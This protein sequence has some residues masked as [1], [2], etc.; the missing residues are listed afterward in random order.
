MY[1]IELDKREDKL[2]SLKDSKNIEFGSQ[3]RNYTLEPYTLVKDVRTG[4]ENINT[5]KVLD[6]DI[7]PFIDAYLKWSK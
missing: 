5:T 4:Y 1:K 3:I 6:G 7:Q 2:N